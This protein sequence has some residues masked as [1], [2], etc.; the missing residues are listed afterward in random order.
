MMKL[1]TTAAMLLAGAI[2]GTGA[3][4]VYAQKYGVT[5]TADKNT[6]FT[7]I[8][9]Y[10]WTPGRPSPDKVVDALIVAAVDRELAGVGLTKAASGAGDVQVAYSS[11]GRTD[12]DVNARPDA[13]GVRPQRS[14]GTVVVLMLD[15]SSRRELL[16]LRADKPVEL[17]ASRREAEINQAVAELFAKYPARKK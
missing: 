5:V 15:P 2:V 16:R 6:D 8:K 9:S 17:E 13:N 1:R 11:V 7:K 10:T 14:V 3:P 12:V 4:G